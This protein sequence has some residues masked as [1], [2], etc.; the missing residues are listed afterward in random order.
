MIPSIRQRTLVT[1]IHDIV[2]ILRLSSDHGTIEKVNIM[3]ARLERHNNKVF[4]LILQMTT[5]NLVFCFVT[6][7][8]DW[9]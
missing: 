3:E 4:K 8:G 9:L 6:K 1:S 5:Q 2:I 7:K